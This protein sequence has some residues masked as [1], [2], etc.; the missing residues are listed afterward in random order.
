[1]FYI[2]DGILKMDFAPGLVSL[3]EYLKL[4]NPSEP[5]PL[6]IPR[7]GIPH[8]LGGYEAL[9]VIFVYSIPKTADTPPVSI[10]IIHYS[11]S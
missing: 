4:K 9:D 1:M 3:Q 5:D 2:L 8:W 6:V 10:P 7:A 11:C